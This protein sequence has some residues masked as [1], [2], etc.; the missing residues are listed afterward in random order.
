MCK[1]RYS[2]LIKMILGTMLIVVSVFS[3]VCFLCSLWIDQ[4]INTNYLISILLCIILWG[5][6]S[7]TIGLLN[8]FLNSR[9]IFGKENIQ[10]KKHV[11]HKDAVSIR[12]FKFYLSVTEPSLVLPKLYINANEISLICYLSKRDTKRLE[13][14]GYDIQQI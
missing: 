3:W 5:I 13:K 12:Y 1:W 7:I 11:I 4:Y 6:V 2:Y 9:I 8:V 14:M 10:Y